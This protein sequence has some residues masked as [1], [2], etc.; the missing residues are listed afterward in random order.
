MD[1][2]KLPFCSPF[3]YPLNFLITFT[4][5]DVYFQ[6]SHKINKLAFGDYYPGKVNPLDG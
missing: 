1:K 5:D 6:I 4:N 3:I 2:L